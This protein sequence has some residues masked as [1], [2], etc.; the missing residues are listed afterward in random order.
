MNKNF[1]LLIGLLP[2][3]IISAT[4]DQPVNTIF[5]DSVR[6]NEVV[7]TGSM[8]EVSKRQLPL[9]VEVIGRKE[10]QQRKTNSLLPI[11]SERIPGM[12]VTQR[13]LMGYGVAAGSAGSMT[14]RG[15]GGSPN[16]Q[17]LVLIDGHPQYMGLMGH[18]LPD[19]YETAMAERVEVIK[20]PASYLYGSNAMGGV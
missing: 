5:R 14:M 8:T 17:L 4:S 10:I 13:G 3:G 18:P 7:V 15:I 9:H 16:T 19:M 2:V 6:L 12:F 11:L 20:G 1:I